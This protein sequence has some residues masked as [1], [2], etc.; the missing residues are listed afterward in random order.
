M[1]V[2]RSKAYWARHIEALEQ[3]GVSMVDYCRG[4]GLD[5]GA[6]ADWRRR[7]GFAQERRQAPAPPLVPILVETTTPATLIEIRVVHK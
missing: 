1:A 5:Y 7:L 4:H 6:L 3:S 2:R